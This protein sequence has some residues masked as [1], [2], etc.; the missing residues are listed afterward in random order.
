[1]IPVHKT[2][3]VRDSGV[4]E[5]MSAIEAHQ[6]FLTRSGSRQNKAREF[7]KNEVA[8]ILIERLSRSV[9]TAFETSSGQD[10]LNQ[11]VERQLDPYAAADLISG[12]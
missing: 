12:N 10:V 8:D 6:A 3:A 9:L 11:R 4:A 5:L 2:E 1:M 7:L